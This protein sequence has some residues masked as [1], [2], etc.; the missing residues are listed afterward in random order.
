MLQ[1]LNSVKNGNNNLKKKEETIPLERDN[2]LRIESTTPVL[3]KQKGTYRLRAWS[4]GKSS[5]SQAF[6]EIHF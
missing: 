5:P 6:L 2:F 1:Y 4:M 3:L